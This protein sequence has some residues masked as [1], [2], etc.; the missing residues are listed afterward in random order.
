MPDLMSKGASREL[1]LAVWA[2]RKWVAIL[3]FAFSFS[4]VAS[5]TKALPDL[6]RADTTIMVEQELPDNAIKAAVSGDLELRLQAVNQQVLSR[7]HLQELIESFNLY[8]VMRAQAHSEMAIERMRSD[9]HFA[10]KQAEQRYGRSTTVSFTLGYQGWDPQIVAQVSNGLALFY[11]K[12]N[13]SLRQHEVVAVQ[14]ATISSGTSDLLSH[15]RQELMDLRTHFSDVYPDVIRLK[16]EIDALILYQ[17]SEVNTTPEPASDLAGGTVAIATN[18]APD[19]NTGQVVGTQFRIL[20]Y[21]IA[22]VQPD[23]PNR[24]RL[25]LMGFMLSLVLAATAVFVL[26]QFDASF[27]RVDELRSY[28][29]VPVL[30]SIS[31]IAT[32]TD[33]WRQRASFLLGMMLSLGVLVEIVRLSYAVGHHGESL[34]WVL[35]S[36]A[37]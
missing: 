1:I 20:D 10:R 16:A 23:G 9:I 27:H 13:E 6:Y 15:K 14:T 18:R 30:A 7:Q 21:A 36:R 19:V 3:I 33:T 22:P 17:H 25:L 37:P 34:V 32:R 12:Q 11:V 35:S 29:R 5:F 8:P 28:T 26:E 31:R 24:P 4:A 2:R